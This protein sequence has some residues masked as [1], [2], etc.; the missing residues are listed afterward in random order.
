MIIGDFNAKIGRG[1]N[2]GVYSLD[3]RNNREID[4]CN[5]A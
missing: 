4:S 2:I 3:T 5:S 1:D